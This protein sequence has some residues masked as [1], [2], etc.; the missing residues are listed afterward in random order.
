[1]TPERFE[2]IIRGATESWDV[3]CKLEFLDSGPC[4]LLRMNEGKVSIS[5]EL[6]SFGT[7]WRIIGLD[8]RERV[9]PSLGSTL[10]SLSRILRPNQPNARVIFAR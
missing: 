9:H 3:E 10:S 4:C 8:G 2:V 7:V 5:H 6:A 1:M